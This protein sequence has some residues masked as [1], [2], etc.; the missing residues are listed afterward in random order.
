MSEPQG[1]RLNEKVIAGGLLVLLGVLFILDNLRV[2]D[3]GN[4]WDY[5]PLFLI[6]PGFARL[7]SPGRPGQRLWGGILVVVGGL[8]LLRNLGI[9]WVPFHRVWPV[10]L[11]A[12]GANLI[13]QAMRRREPPASGGGGGGT[14]NP[15]EQAF[16][17]TKAGL[18]ASSGVRGSPVVENRLDAFALC[19]GGSRR[20]QSSDF[21]GGN[22]T[23]IA[24]GFDIDL[25]G[26]TMPSDSAVIEVFVLMGGAVFRIPESWNAVLN[27]TPLIGG[28]DCKSRM[29]SPDE[30]PVK[31]LTINGFILMGGVEVK[32]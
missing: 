32:N 1:F 4:L 17:G 8:L 13:W 6:G 3:A 30:G 20:I 19:G 9:F 22:V 27:V 28:T 10:A 16:A 31:T 26:A 15:G 18:D 25:R 12:I 24:G 14:M 7:L 11:V 2:I 21:H 29:H 5:W 23:V